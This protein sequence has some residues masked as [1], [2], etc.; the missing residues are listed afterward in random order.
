M[1]NSNVKTLKIGETDLDF[2]FSDN[3]FKYV[4]FRIKVLVTLNNQPKFLQCPSK[5]PVKRIKYH[6]IEKK[7]IT[8]H[9]KNY[10]L[11]SGN[12]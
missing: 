4:S 9:Q 3:K 8:L 6:C 1:L 7:M 12:Q 5:E 10:N 2:Y 11:V